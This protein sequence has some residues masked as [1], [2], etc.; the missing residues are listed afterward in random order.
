MITDSQ[1]QAVTAVANTTGKAIDLVG[2]I[3][4]FLNR[5]VG[6]IPAN[7]IR[8]GGGDWLNEVAVR[9][10]ARMRAK[11]AQILENVGRDRITEPSPSI[12][13][14]LLQTAA[15][16]SREQLQDLWAALL[17]N[18]V[19]DG[20]KRVRRDYFDAVRQL[21]PSDALLLD[22]VRRQPWG[23]FSAQGHSDRA[24][25]LER[26]I[27]AAGLVGDDLWISV[28]KLRQLRCL[29]RPWPGELLSFGKGLVAACQPPQ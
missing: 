11:T 24:A 17:A 2:D 16:E 23:D 13:L 25:F 18:A 4:A 27:A 29:D 8:V 19:V 28:D 5:T 7:L 21:E 6:S 26:E 22:I 15:D 14:P 3:G 9:N 1:A 20:G 12:V 10:L